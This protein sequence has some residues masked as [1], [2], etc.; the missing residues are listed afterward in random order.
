M[1]KLLERFIDFF[2]YTPIKDG[3]RQSSKNIERNELNIEYTNKEIK[4]T[5]R[6]LFYLNSL[7]NHLLAEIDKLNE[8]KK[9]LS[10]K[11]EDENKERIVEKSLL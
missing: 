3:I 5:E 8:W 2:H 10:D 9:V 6:Q 11:L 4:S 1:G 7:K